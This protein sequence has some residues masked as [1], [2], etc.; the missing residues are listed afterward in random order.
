MEIRVRQRSTTMKRTVNVLSKL[1][2]GTRA[3]SVLVLCATT[4]IA[5]PAQ[6]LTTLYT[7]CSQTGCPDGD[8]PHAGLVQATNGDLYGTTWG[9]GVNG[10]G[11]V[12]KITQGGTLTTLYSFCSQTNCTDGTG[13]YAGLVQ[14]ANGD[15]FGTTS[16]GYD[17]VFKIT[18][19]GT[20]T[21]LYS[22]CSQTNCTDGATPYAGLVQAANGDLYGTAY[23]GGA[24]GDLGT[25]FK[26]TPTGTLTT[27]Y[28]FCSQSGCTDGAHPAGGLVQA[29]NG[30]FY[31]TTESGG[32]AHGGGTVFKITPGGTL[33]TLYRFCSQSGCPDGSDPVAG[34]VQAADGDFYGTTSGGGASNGGTIFKITPGGTLTTLYSFCAQGA[35]PY[36]T[37][38]ARPVAGLV[39]DTNRDFYGT[40]AGGGS[41]NDGTVFRLSVGLGPFVKIRPPYGNVGAAVKILGTNLTGAASV[42]FNGTAA[43]FT[44]VSSSEITTTVPAGASS[45]KVQVITPSGTLSSN[46][47]FLVVP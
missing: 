5:L 6:T 42:S 33:T 41:N 20:L 3:S 9:G 47:S 44:V 11:T 12:F 8:G 16:N 30:N 19:G 4:A 37:D 21:T 18:P 31:G 23:N 40:T 24:N 43:V 7:F 32:R 28:S 10:Q 13:P 45:G 25:V 46:A 34:V 26:I 29:A 27:L 1:N 14:A 35:F 38:G 36:C 22:F 17:T 2:W 15:F 39:Q